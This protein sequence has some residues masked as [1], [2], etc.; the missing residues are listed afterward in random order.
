MAYWPQPKRVVHCGAKRSSQR[1]AKSDLMCSICKVGNPQT[2]PEAEISEVQLVGGATPAYRKPR[3]LNCKPH[4]L[5]LV[6][7]RTP[8]PGHKPLDTT[9]YPGHVAME[10]PV[11]PGV[12]VLPSEERP[13]LAVARL[14]RYGVNYLQDGKLLL[15]KLWKFAETESNHLSL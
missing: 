2:C 7:L 4:T 3:E 5:A 6:L 1:P 11:W 13:L 14:R 10:S 15:A 9:D 12:E 8:R